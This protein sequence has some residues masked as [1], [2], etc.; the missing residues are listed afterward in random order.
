MNS[1]LGLRP[2][3]GPGVPARAAGGRRAAARRGAG[4]LGL[5]P[6]RDDALRQPRRRLLGHQPAPGRGGARA[7]TSRATGSSVIYTGVDAERGV[8]ARAGAPD[9]RPGAG[10]RARAVPRPA[11]RAEGPAADGRG[12]GRRCA[13]RGLRF[14]IHVVGEGELEARGARG[15]DERGLAEDACCSIPPTSELPRWYAACDVL[16]MT[17]VFEGVPYV[18]YEAM[19]MGLPSW[20]PALPGQRRAARRRPAGSSS[21]ATTSPATRTRWPACSRTAA[22]ARSSGRAGASACSGALLAAADGGTSTAR[23]YDECSA[24]ARAARRTGT[25][26]RRS[27]RSASATAVCYDTPLVSVIVPCFNHGRYLARVRRGGAGADLPGDRDHRRRRRLHRP[28]DATRCSTSSS[29]P[30]T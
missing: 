8:L 15:V 16:L 11:R 10:S 6:L 2:A 27:R 28:G 23:L 1:R 5:R 13:T 29:G 9:R 25:P 17:S 21:R 24:R 20:R 22:G 4:P 12:G 26:G 7:T 18:V 14:Q 30:T 19:A 3:A